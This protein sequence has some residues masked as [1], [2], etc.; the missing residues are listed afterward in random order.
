M[1]YLQKDNTELRVLIEE[2]HEAFIGKKVEGIIVIKEGAESDN[3][4]KEDRNEDEAEKKQD[5]MQ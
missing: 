1:A 5:A 3:D 2:M 4:D